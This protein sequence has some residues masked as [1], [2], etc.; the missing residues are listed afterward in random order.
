MKDTEIEGLEKCECASS[1]MT[2]A[3]VLHIEREQMIPLEILV[4]IDYGVYVCICTVYSKGIKQHTQHTFFYDTYS[5]TKVK[6][7]WYGAVID[8]RTYAPICVMEV[9][10]RNTKA[11][12][13]NMLRKLFQGKCV[14]R[15]AFKVT[16]RDFS[17][18]IN[19]LDFLLYFYLTHRI[20]RLKTEPKSYSNWPDNWFLYDT[21]SEKCYKP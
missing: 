18:H 7:A 3:Y 12:L 15:F 8:N 21:I 11:P 20:G 1:V 9:K 17:W 6:I 14:V 2:I 10:D 5:S 13:N 19:N 16:S 4:R